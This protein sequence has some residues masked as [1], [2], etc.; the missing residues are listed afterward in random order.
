MDDKD[1]IFDTFT[2][3]PMKEDP[4]AVP[5][6]P[7]EVPV[8]IG[9]PVVNTGV[10]M[11]IKTAKRIGAARVERAV[12]N[13]KE[14]RDYLAKIGSSVSDKRYFPGSG[15]EESSSDEFDE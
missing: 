10:E 7:D 1:N 3:E 8:K 11:M 13:S 6:L 5:V 2:V 15:I 4:E 12:N 14:K 9:E